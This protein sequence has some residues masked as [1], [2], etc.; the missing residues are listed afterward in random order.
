MSIQEPK[1]IDVNEPIEE[2]LPIKLVVLGKSLVGKSA[3]T[4]RFISDK[5]PT[6]HDTTVEDQYKT[7]ITVND[8][9]CELEILDTAGQDDYQ[10]M[11]DTWIDFGNCFL[12]VYA[13]DDMDS[14][15]Q[16]KF[17]YDRIC[18]NKKDEKISVVIVGNKCD[19]ED[20]KR[21]VSKNEAE[22]LGKNLGVTFLEVSALKRV[23]V[24]EAFT[25]VV[26]EYLSKQ[27]KKK[28]HENNVAG[29]CPCF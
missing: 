21:K 25:Q 15:K 8:T 5:F 22:N 24:K 10:T 11:L 28:H 27:K 19:L 13:I 17:K 3:L 20:S 12:L 1:I 2:T 29:G 6:E 26:H 14:F 7:V 9:S 16:I 18:Q 4:Q 23:N